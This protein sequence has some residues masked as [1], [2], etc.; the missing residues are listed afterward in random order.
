MTTKQKQGMDRTPQFD[1]FPDIVNPLTPVPEEPEKTVPVRHFVAP[2][3]DDIFLGN[4]PLQKF[5]EQ[6]EQKTPA[7]VA[8]VLN[9]MDWSA[10]EARYAPTGRP[11]YA[12]RNMVG[13]IVYGIMQGTTSLRALENMA[14]L[15]LGCMWVSG[16]I[17]PDHAIIGRFINM[18]E[19]SLTGQF[20][21]D[22]VRAVLKI[23]GSGGERLA[24]DGTTIEA[25][26]SHYNL[27]KEEAA[28]A[29]WEK[30]QQRAEGDPDN[31]EKQ[32]ACEK[33]HD[34]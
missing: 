2:Q 30:A 16:G 14:R 33:A 10:F 31:K 9:Q 8:S 7:I 1:I 32:C 22:L 34:V 21:D 11:P 5:L 24:G 15:D 19:K 6:V 13:L 18:H 3:P 27:M 17:Y 25:A 29:A 23:T 20:F 12:P 4:T 26:C 28:K